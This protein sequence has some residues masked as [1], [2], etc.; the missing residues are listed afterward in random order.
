MTRTVNIRT[1]H[2]NAEIIADAIRPDNTTEMKT[3]VT[4]DT[5]ITTITRGTTGGLRTT[6]DD[7][8]CNLQVAESIVSTS[9]CIDASRTEQLNS[10]ETK[11]RSNSDQNTNSH[12]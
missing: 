8:L 1:I 7:Y 11:T 5:I 2:K 9:Q 3:T 10:T 4:D 6:I 12:T